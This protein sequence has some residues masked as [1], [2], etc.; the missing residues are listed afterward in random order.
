MSYAGG[1]LQG[2]LGLRHARRRDDTGQRQGRLL[3]CR[4]LHSSMRSR[5]A[6]LDAYL[7]ACAQWQRDIFRV[8]SGWIN[9]DGR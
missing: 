8:F 3:W 2:S 7:S 4:W 9:V 5:S 6:R 1:G